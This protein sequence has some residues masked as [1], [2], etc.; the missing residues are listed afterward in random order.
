MAEERNKNNTNCKRIMM[1]ERE[2]EREIGKRMCPCIF[3][4]AKSQEDDV[5]PRQKNGLIVLVEMGVFVLRRKKMEQW[6]G[7]SSNYN[8]AP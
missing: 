7:A 3:T 5:A 2:R 1:R 6:V 8:K 4:L